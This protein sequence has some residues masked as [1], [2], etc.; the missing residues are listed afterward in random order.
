MRL[1]EGSITEAAGSFEA[2]PSEQI[3]NLWWPRDRAWFVVT[4]ID[5]DSTIV[6]GTRECIDALTQSPGVEAFTIPG[7]LDLSTTL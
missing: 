5:F 4:E 6:A 3:A 2:A 1:W 7:D